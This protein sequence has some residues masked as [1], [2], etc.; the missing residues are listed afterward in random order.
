MQLRSALLIVGALAWSTDLRADGVKFVERASTEVAAYADTDHV[1]VFTPSISGH[2]ENPT[3][4][5]SLDG[6]YLVDAI[7]AASV[8]VIS[9]A[10]GR[11]TEV[12]QAGDAR[13][14]YR[15]GDWGERSKD[16]CRASLTISRLLPADT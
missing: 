3:A 7:S 14:A 8:D 2:I 4:G 10:S 15:R 16:P 5:W 11:W 6:S 9:T 12:R 1:A 13:F